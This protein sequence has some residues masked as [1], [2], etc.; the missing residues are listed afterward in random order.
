MR[1]GRDGEER[2]RNYS[3][4]FAV[5]MDKAQINA[6][7]KSTNGNFVLGEVALQQK[8]RVLWRDAFC[9]EVRVGSRKCRINCP[10]FLWRE[11]VNAVCINSI[12]KFRHIAAGVAF[13]LSGAASAWDATTHV[14]SVLAYNDG[15]VWVTFSDWVGNNACGS[16]G[17]SLGTAGAVQQKAMQSVAQQAMATGKSITVSTV[18]GQCNG[19]QEVVRSIQLNQ[20]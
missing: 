16:N 8:L 13:F 1:L 20:S 4:L 5:H 19:G 15:H 10:R 7:T 9:L 17:F 11:I 12:K 3:A 6:I 2:R 18:S 14:S